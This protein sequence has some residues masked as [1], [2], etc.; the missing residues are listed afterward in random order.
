MADRGQQGRVTGSLWNPHVQGF[1]PPAHA[2]LSP[3]RARAGEGRALSPF[4]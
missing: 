1:S 3:Q 4:C 2:E